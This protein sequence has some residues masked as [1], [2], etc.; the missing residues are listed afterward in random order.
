[1]SDLGSLNNVPSCDPVSGECKCKLN[2]HGR[3]CKECKMG[4]MGLVSNM[5]LNSPDAQNPFGCTPC[6]CYGHSN[7]CTPAK[8]FVKSSVVSAFDYDHENWQNVHLEPVQY[9]KVL[10]S[11]STESSFLFP[12]EFLQDQRYC[13]NQ[14]LRFNLRVSHDSRR[15]PTAGD[16]LITG[17]GRDQQ[18]VTLSTP[19][20]SQGNPMPTD[21]D[22]QFEFRI[23][24]T[25]FSPQIEP[26]SFIS[27]LNNVTS[28]QLRL[29]GQGQ[30]DMVELETA[31]EGAFGDEAN[32]VEEC[33]APNRSPKGDS[34]IDHFTFDSDNANPYQPCMPCRCNMHGRL[35]CDRVTGECQCEHNT[36]GHYCDTC[37]EG[38]YGD[39]YQGTSSDCKACPCPNGGACHVTRGIPEGATDG[40]EVMCTGC[41]PGSGGSRCHKCLDNYFGDP[42]G[43]HGSAKPCVE[44]RCNGNINKLVAGNCDAVTGRCEKCLFNTYGD[45]CEKCREGFYGDPAAAPHEQAHGQKG[46]VA[47]QCYKKGSADDVCDPRNGQCSCL[48]GV[49]G[50]TCDQCKPQHFGLTNGVGCQA[51]DCHPIGLK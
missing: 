10:G 41:A 35:P 39:P 32:W 43:R 24:E 40:I 26:V 21:Q 19:L 8:H 33:Q 36:C 29:D 2:V 9:N 20:N 18:H 25:L 7:T 38:F 3:Q 44:C 34:C 50:L 46:C 4:Y 16:L 45:H 27:V 48:P 23:H 37:C 13:Y 1:M 22:Q 15:T 11:I 47:C 49:G 51:C 17:V 42:L 28:I 14:H 12:K 6:F 31:E 5:R 30:L